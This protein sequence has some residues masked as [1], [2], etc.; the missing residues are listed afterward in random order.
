MMEQ[1][2]WATPFKG[3]RKALRGR[4][5]PEG[6]AAPA[7]PAP[8][9]P[10]EKIDARDDEHE[11]FRQ[12]M[13]DVREIEKFR[14]LPV[15]DP[16][17][18][19]VGPAEPSMSEEADEAERELGLIIRKKRGITLS[20][21][22]EYMEWAAP[23][24]TAQK[25][26]DL[27][28]RLHEGQY[29]VADHIDLHGLTEEDAWD[30]LTDFLTHARKRNLP[31]IKI[32]HGRGL[33]SPGEPVLKGAVKRWLRGPLSKHVLAFATARASDGGLGA[34]YVLLKR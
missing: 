28:R 15:R 9:A 7:P 24:L 2:K 18:P 5:K 17:I 1:D 3:L 20:D 32:I 30:S 34:T 19:P 21:T 14:K 11:A 16:G 33:R 22:D 27:T 26:R 29:A 10:A 8:A 12:A 23:S 25:R 6:K 13:A 4:R 31:C